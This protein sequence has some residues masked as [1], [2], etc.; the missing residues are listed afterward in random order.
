VGRDRISEQPLEDSPRWQHSPM[1]D[2]YQSCM[3]FP[4]CNERTRI[5]LP[6]FDAEV[7]GLKPCSLSDYTAY[8]EWAGIHLI[9]HSSFGRV[10]HH[11]SPTY[12][13]W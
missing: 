11:L 5:I 3:H 9:D 1:I 2:H 10:L 12:V 6:T 8:F 4:I 13:F 7:V